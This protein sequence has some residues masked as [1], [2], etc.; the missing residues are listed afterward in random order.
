MATELEKEKAIAELLEI[1]LRC[2]HCNEIL[3]KANEREKR[4]RDSK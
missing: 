4:K 1:D 3:E 2:P